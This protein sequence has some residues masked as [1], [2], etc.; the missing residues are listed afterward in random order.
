[1]ERKRKLFAAKSALILGV[2]PALIW[3]YEYGPDAGHAGVPNELGTC[4]SS[5][6]HVGTL[7]GSGG[8]VAVTFPNGTTY[9]PG[10]TQHL[11]VTISDSAASQRAWGF[12]LTAR[13]SDPATMAGSF[14]STDV[15]TLLMCAASDNLANEREVD[16]S[17]TR[18][19][20]CPSGMQLQYIEHSLLGYE[21]TLGQSGS[22]SYEFDWTPPASDVG[23]IV[24]YVAANAGLANLTQNGAHIYT[25]TYT[26]TPAT[27]S[28]TPPAI[29]SGGVVNGASFQPG[30]VP[31]SW[32]TIQGS[33]LSPVTDTWAN[34]IV[35]GALPT[36]LDGVSVS[37]GGKPAYIYFISGQQINAVA[38]DAGTGT[39]SVTVTTPSGTS[40]AVS[41]N[42][43][44]A[45]PAFFLWDNQYAVATRQDFSWAVKN[46]TFSGTTTVPAKPGDVII[47]WGTGF[48]PTT[49]AA[50]IGV[51]VPSDQ[52]Y[53]TVNPVTVTVG[54]LPAQVF[55]AALA[56][57]FAGLYQVAIQVPANAPNGDLPVV[58]TVAGVPSP[59][60][61]TLTV[62]Q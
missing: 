25:A 5:Q 10:A 36:K 42:E 14:A 7:N 27:S 56:P 57:G 59:S 37:V 61:V 29:A 18:A 20:A 46:G 43:Q 26:L 45:S 39:M 62:Q 58:A 32:I 60:D 31:D 8:G 55:G 52:A 49:P 38:P 16:F 9:T 11:V 48:G 21:A 53:A 12:Q 44:T 28:G 13:T 15:K 34:A 1:M 19:Q 24:L 50:P 41:T 35:D 33:N 54:G 4:L 30:I 2:V 40:A 17:S 3:A 23:D 47:L 22:A 6:C 51:Q